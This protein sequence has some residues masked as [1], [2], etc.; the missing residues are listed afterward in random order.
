[1]RLLGETTSTAI[2]AALFGLLST[3]E[4]LAKVTDEVRAAFEQE[5]QIDVASA[6]RLPYLT[7]VIKEGM[8]LGPPSVLGVPRVTPSGGAQICGRWVPGGVRCDNGGKSHAVALTDNTTDFGRNQSV[9]GF[10][11][12]KEL[13]GSG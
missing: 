12:I 8:R 4:A 3:R 11:L 1:M 2:S 9:S 6:A 10:P 13:H 7:A 5:S